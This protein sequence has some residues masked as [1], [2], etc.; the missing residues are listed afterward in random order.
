MNNLLNGIELPEVKV[1]ITMDEENLKGLL[2][3]L[4]LFGMVLGISLALVLYLFK[5]STK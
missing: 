5:S 1:Q 2:I 3:N 4:Y